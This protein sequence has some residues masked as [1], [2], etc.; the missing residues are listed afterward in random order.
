[1]EAL[2]RLSSGRAEIEGRQAAAGKRAHAARHPPL[3]LRASPRKAARELRL[4]YQSLKDPRC[5]QVWDTSG[6]ACSSGAAGWPRRRRAP[7]VCQAALPASLLP[8]A[9]YFARSGQDVPG[10]SCGLVRPRPGSHTGSALKGVAKAAASP[11]LVQKPLPSQPTGPARAR[12]LHDTGA[13]V[14]VLSRLSIGGIVQQCIPPLRK[15][16]LLPRRPPPLR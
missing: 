2:C 3:S 1:M 8:T 5:V 16:S 7:G 15:S 13:S 9:I 6:R 12:S 14:S 4:Q 10:S 11:S